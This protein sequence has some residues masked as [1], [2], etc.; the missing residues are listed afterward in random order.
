[1]PR[2]P[3][4]RAGKS[5]RPPADLSRPPSDPH[6]PPDGNRATSPP[7]DEG[8][9]YLAEDNDLHP[10]NPGNIRGGPSSRDGK[11]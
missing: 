11:R 9:R 4:Y 6:L 7:R 10:N 2:A 8:G 3:Q 1:M 5:R